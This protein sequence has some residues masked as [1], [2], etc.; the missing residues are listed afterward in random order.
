MSAGEKL[1]DGEQQLAIEKLATLLG[2]SGIDTSTWGT[3]GAKTVAHLYKEI[4]DGESQMSFGPEGVT[5]AV[6]VAWLDVLFFDEQGDVYLLAEDRQEY[7]DGRVRRRQLS[8]SL[9]EK[10][11][12]DEDPDE[13]AVRALSEELGAWSY[14][15]LHAIGYERTTHTPDSYPGL[16]STY[17]TYSYVAVLDS[18][19]YKPEG[20][21]EV[22][23][24]KTNYYTWTKIHSEHVSGS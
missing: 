19:S 8:S 5:R 22:Q 18:A 17:D 10:L 23:A 16:E 13:A 20:Y 11:K 7:R 6:R 9:G 14:Q 3:G 15:S 24:D 12:P 1:R 21:I 2:E 4:C